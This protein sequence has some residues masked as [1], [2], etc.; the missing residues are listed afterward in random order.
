MFLAPKIVV[1]K[2][3]LKFWTG[4]RKFGLHLIIVQNFAPIGRRI[5]EISRWK[6]KIKRLRQKHKSAPKII[7]SWRTN[8]GI[9]CLDHPV[10]S[11]W[12]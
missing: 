7:V 8:L 11:C 10:F 9:R 2:S 6:E 12:C 3:P 4:I 5:S 1:K